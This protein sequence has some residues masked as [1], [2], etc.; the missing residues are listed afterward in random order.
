MS[1]LRI[2]S[3]NEDL[4]NSVVDFLEKQDNE[5]KKDL[6]LITGSA[7]VPE[8]FLMYFPRFIAKFDNLGQ[9]KHVKEL[10]RLVE[11]VREY[12]FHRVNDLK[13]LR[14]QRDVQHRQQLQYF[15]DNWDRAFPNDPVPS[16]FA[17]YTIGFLTNEQIDRVI[18]RITKASDKIKALEEEIR[19][20]RRNFRIN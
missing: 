8:T 12:A 13:D 16:S 10:G 19:P 15:Y 6:K 4:I 5:K 11:P 17:C 3:D 7:S 1:M 18:N 14:E 2:Q 20:V 9:L